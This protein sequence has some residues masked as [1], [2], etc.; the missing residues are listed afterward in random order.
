M[1]MIQMSRSTDTAFENLTSQ[2]LWKE[3]ENKRSF[4]F[5]FYA[6]DGNESHY[7][8]IIYPYFVYV[9]IIST[10][11]IADVMDGLVFVH[12]EKRSCWEILPCTY[13]K[14][15]ERKKDPL[16]T[17]KPQGIHFFFAVKPNW[18]CHLKFSVG[19]SP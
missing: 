7:F 10:V 11:V 4:F 15:V 19:F 9:R 2:P 5:Y 13:F 17:K 8:H 1:I 6:N 12:T 14:N 3:T 18:I 16:I